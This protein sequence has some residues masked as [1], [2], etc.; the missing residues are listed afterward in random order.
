NAGMAYVYLGSPTGVGTTAI[1]RLTG[2]TQDNEFFG[3]V[4]RAGDVNGDC[5]DDLVVGGPFF[6]TSKANVG[7]AYL[8]LGS[9]S[10]PLASSCRCGGQ[11]ASG[12]CASGICCGQ[13]CTGQCEVCDATGS[14]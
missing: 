13:A 5:V 14:C 11:C 12:I 7:R 2:A 9:G 1:A 8:W 10:R 4:A 6:D 3:N